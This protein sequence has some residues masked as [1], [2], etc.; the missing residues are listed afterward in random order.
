MSQP[1]PIVWP[2]PLHVVQGSPE[3]LSGIRVY[4]DFDWREEFGHSRKAFPHGQTLTR[5]IKEECPAGKQPCLLLTT[6]EDPIPQRI[7]RQTEY[8]V[9]VNIRHYLRESE[10][11]PAYTYFAR[12]AKGC[13]TG[14]PAVQNVA[15]TAEE[16]DAFLNTHLKAGDIARW[17]DADPDRL[18]QLAEITEKKIPG[19]SHRASIED[20]I[21]TLE[22]LDRI[23]PEL[24]NGL[25]SV[26]SKAQDRQ[27]RTTLLHALTHNVEGLTQAG[28]VFGERIGAVVEQEP[29]WDPQGK[30]I[31]L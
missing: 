28:E 4:Y 6:G 9:V 21:Q 14:I 24:L 23:D 10:G 3:R 27:T 22:S 1:D 26:F 29:L 13:V 2:R 5:L 17:L 19:R 31:K 7:P 18:Q 30:R 25:K 11:N 16:L 12:S 15:H 8:V 20:V